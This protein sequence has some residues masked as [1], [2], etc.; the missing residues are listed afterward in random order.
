[1]K[2][3]NRTKADL[4][5]GLQSLGSVIDQCSEGIALTDEDGVIIEWNKRLAAMTGVPAGEALGRPIWDVQYRSTPR[6]AQTQELR[7]RLEETIR[8]Y[9]RTGEIPEGHK[10]STQ[11]L[12]H[13]DGRQRHQIHSVFSVKT[14]KGYMLGSVTQDVTEQH[15][16]E[17]ALEKSEELFRLTFRTSPDAFVISRMDDGQI[18]DANDAFCEMTGYSR[19][20]VIGALARETNIW[21]SM[22]NRAKFVAELERRGEVQ[23]MEGEIQT[24][25]GKRICWLIS[26]RTFELDGIPHALSTAKNIDELKETEK[27][28]Q[29]TNTLLKTLFNNTRIQFAYLDPQFNFIEVNRAYAEADDQ[30]SEYFPGKNHFDLYP[31]RENQRIF[32][33]VVTSRRP[34]SGAAKAS[35]YAEHSEHGT[36]YLDWSLVPVKTE[37]GEVEGLVLAVLDV[38]ERVEAEQARQES[39]A[40]FRSMFESS[41]VGI[42]RVS[43]DYRIVDINQ[44]YC[45][46]LGYTRDEFVGMSI[47]D[48]TDPESL[49]EN[50]RRQAGLRRGEINSYQMEKKYVR[51]D[52]EAVWV[53]LDASLVR[54]TNGNPLYFLG[55]VVDITQRKRTES[56]NRNLSIAVEQS[57]VAIVVTDPEG[58]IEYVNA[59]FCA[60]SGYTKQEALGQNPRILKSGEQPAEMYEDLWATITSGGT[61][62]GEFHN[63]KK[64]GELYWEDATIGPI[65]NEQG[66]ITHFIAFK[67]DITEKKDLEHQ[68]LQS[69]RLEAIG[70]LAGGVAHDFNNL[71]TVINGYSA[72]VLDK[73]SD[74]DPKRLDIEQIAAAGERAG[75]LTHQLLTFSRKQVIRPVIVDLNAVVGDMTTML[76]RLVG[77]NI[78][79]RTVFADDLCRIRVDPGQMN[80]II[81][82]LAVNARDAMPSGGQ[83]TIETAN[84]EIDREYSARHMGARPG[85]YS[86]VTI[87][88]DGIGMG[89]GTR[90]HAFE[91]FFTTKGVGE[92]TGLGL[93]TVYGIVKQHNGYIW[94]YS[95]LGHGTTVKVYLPRVEVDS[96]RLTG[97]RTN[98]EAPSGTETILLVEDDDTVRKLTTGIL[99]Q[100]GY[101]VLQAANGHQAL[102]V[103]GDESE[104][105]DLLVTDVIMPAMSG[106]ELADRLLADMPELR[107]IFVSGYTDE[108]ISRTGILPDDVALLS[109]PFHPKALLTLVRTVLDRQN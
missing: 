53:L 58:G 78:A 19:E 83:I 68:L 74:G 45:D 52:G 92:G 88:D 104:S 66:E 105:I 21:A 20:E 98:T 59:K 102:D 97:P 13:P 67:E 37:Q 7:A 61:W 108:A 14:D 84:F 95:E 26:A 9:L 87:S 50:K 72:L 56:E 80:Q 76:R 28:L 29:R 23:G 107:V 16:A 54:D 27:T 2:D 70:Q 89:E 51:K 40:L 63:K 18:V 86:M 106:K 64:N 8:G 62:S 33:E 39:D 12:Q 1:M 42:A 31:N 47:W 85:E 24:K 36:T 46:M 55:N 57:P 44:A 79:V 77:E 41:S 15:L 100:S 43:L 75:L 38:T 90:S 82:N 11:V 5:A 71:L 94:L 101:T 10:K 96:E 30:T 4:I 25:D 6:E 109:K 60:I 3:D 22:E 69:Q 17:G 99:E 65:T 49:P 103:F 73:L 81:M 32:E 91:P 48:I 34:Y 35:E 93:S